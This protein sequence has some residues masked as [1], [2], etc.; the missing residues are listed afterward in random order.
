FEKVISNLST[1]EEECE[2]LRNKPCE[3]CVDGQVDFKEVVFN[4]QG[5]LAFHR[6]E[7]IKLKG[8]IKDM[9]A[10]LKA[11]DEEFIKL[12]EENH[13]LKTKEVEKPILTDPAVGPSSKASDDD[14]VHD[15][16]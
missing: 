16:K 11:K 14:G 15:K 13:T 4:L 3:V 1:K 10:T 6:M 7:N 5:D 12:R 2:R 9:S 8:E